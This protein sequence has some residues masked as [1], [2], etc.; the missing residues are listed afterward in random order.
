MGITLRNT[1][2]VELSYNELD[3]NFAELY[4]SSSISGTSISLFSHGTGSF[5]AVTHSMTINTGSTLT[6]YSESGSTGTVTGTFVVS[7]SSN[8]TGNLTVDGTLTAT[9]LV[10]NIVSSSITLTSGS[11]IF[12]DEASDKHEFTGSVEI[13]GRTKIGNNNSLNHSITG[14]TGVS[15]SLSV[16][17]SINQVGTLNV[18]GDST[19]TGNTTLTNSGSTSVTITDGYII[20]TEVSQSLNFADDTAA[21]AGG[22]PLGGLYRNGNFIQIRTS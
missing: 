19:L 17:G 11:N 20:L 12:G 8:M 10:T 22:I 5:T 7:G 6:L 1:K 13:T 3:T 4:N 2:G 9:E 18:T 21:A 16:T 14:S 15:G